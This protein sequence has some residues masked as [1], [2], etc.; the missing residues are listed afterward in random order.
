MISCRS[1]SCCQM[2]TVVPRPTWRQKLTCQQETQTQR[3]RRTQL[4]RPKK[5]AQPGVPKKGHPAAS[6]GKCSSQLNS[7][8]AVTMPRKELCPRGF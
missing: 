6:E 1:H 5:E 2:W 8:L 7:T 3:R 4:S